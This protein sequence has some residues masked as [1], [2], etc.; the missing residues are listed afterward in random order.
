MNNKHID[1]CI[2]M[3]LHE[4]VKIIDSPRLEWYNKCD[5]YIDVRQAILLDLRV[6]DKCTN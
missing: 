2:L 5:I 1:W 3:G 6:R 4:T